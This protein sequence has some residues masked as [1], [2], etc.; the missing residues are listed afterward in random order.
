MKKC[1]LNLKDWDKKLV[2]EALE[3]GIDAIVAPAAFVHRIKELGRI[4][5]V[6]PEKGDM[7]IPEDVEVIII[8]NKDDE[9]RA[10]D[11][12]R[13]KI[14]AVRTT[15]WNIIPIENLIPRGGENL[16]TFVRD[17]NEAK[18]A[19]EIMEKGV[20]GIVLETDNPGE[21][22]SVIKYIKS[23]NSETF[24]L[25]TLQITE[26]RNIGTGDRVC[27]DTV[28]NIGQ[29]EG[30][31]IG[32]SSRGMFLVHAENLDNPYVSPRPFRVNAGAVHS[33]I[34]VPGDKTGYLG[35]LGTGDP[36]LIVNK[37]GNSYMSYVG[38]SK[39]EKRPMVV[40]FAEDE[41]GGRHSIIL[42]NAETIRLTGISGEALSV[43]SLKGGDKVLGFVERGG[44]HFG[45]SVE[46]TINEK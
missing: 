33:Y 10:A 29:G 46:E 35:E 5:V 45:M 37:E 36:V 1:W 24:N 42:Q 38:R 16:F 12:L 2:T 31:L 8:N 39:I 41:E 27:L 3:S 19:L 7:K 30:M 25:I 22:T 15:D 32:N 13:S 34:R 26:I 14:V 11:A 4:T 18:L 43:A 23:I 21:I 20:A 6:A 9:D 40:I 28:S 44:R 17:I